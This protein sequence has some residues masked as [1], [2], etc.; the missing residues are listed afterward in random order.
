MFG[1]CFRHDIC[2]F[3]TQPNFQVMHFTSQ[4]CIICEIVHSRPIS[5]NA[6]ASGIWAPLAKN[7][8]C[9]RHCW[10]WQIS[11]LRQ[12]EPLRWTEAARGSRTSRLFTIRGGHQAPITNCFH[13]RWADLQFLHQ[14]W[15]WHRKHF[16]LS[17]W[18]V[19]WARWTHRWNYSE[20]PIF[21]K[22]K[23]SGCQPSLPPPHWAKG[24]PLQ[25]HQVH[26]D[27]RDVALSPF[28]FICLFLF[29]FFICPLSACTF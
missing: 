28:F 18:I 23:F 25:G 15:N 6:L 3:F 16:S 27:Q 13:Q 9:R 4:L 8:H 11:A 29:A 20:F 17:C 26:N 10:H 1:D 7:L 21:A 2:H 14:S 19:P 22:S 24:V 5:V 12:G